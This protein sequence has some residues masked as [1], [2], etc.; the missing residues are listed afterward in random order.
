MKR[1]ILSYLLIS[2]AFCAFAQNADIDLLRNINH[3]RNRNL[4]PFFQ[5]TSNSVLPM[6]IGVPA[7][8]AAI[9]LITKDSLQKKKT[10]FVVGTI[11]IS[12]AITTSIK[13]AVKR[14]RPFVTYPDIEKETVA[15]SLS[16]PSGHTS[17][18]FSLATAM[19]VAYPKW[20]V[21]A[22]AYIWASTVAYSRMDLGAHYPSDVLAGA[23]IGSGS[24]YLS[25]KLNN[26]LYKKYRK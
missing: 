3:N 5:F 9:Q 19:S 12:G 25:F 20:Y 7:C 16:F 24:A 14:P 2:F 18:A 4:D 10:I 13:Y 11:L 22:P 21:I 23:I 6:M 26:W 8:M 15:G 1:T 17:S